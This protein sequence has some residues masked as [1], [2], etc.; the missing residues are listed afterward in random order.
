MFYVLFR[1]LIGAFTLIVAVTT[2]MILLVYQ[3]AS[4]VEDFRQ[5]ENFYALIKMHFV[6]CNGLAMVCLAS[7]TPLVTQGE[8]TLK[9]NTPLSHPGLFG[10]VLLC[11]FT[12]GLHII[13]E[14]QIINNVHPFYTTQVG[15][16]IP[17]NAMIAVISTIVYLVGFWST[18]IRAEHNTQDHKQ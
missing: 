7:V 18:K 3:D 17:Q 12:I 8:E 16:Q 14:H 9:M 5:R 15:N 13:T 4:V 6:I 10:L 11:L 1:Y 2:A